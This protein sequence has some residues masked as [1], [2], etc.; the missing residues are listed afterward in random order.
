[1]DKTI[2]LSRLSQK[3]DKKWQAELPNGRVVRFGARGYSDY[4][5]HKDPLRMER[6]VVRHGGSSSGFRRPVNV[7]REMLKK[8]RSSK[9]KWGRNGINTPGFWSRWLLW[10]YPTINDARTHIQNKVL[11]GYR[12]IIKR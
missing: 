12:I 1:M 3:S 7:Q 11:K 8:V 10:S 2:R 6:Y 5:L 9:E 4:T